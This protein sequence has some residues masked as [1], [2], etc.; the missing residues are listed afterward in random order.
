MAAAEPEG[1]L[2][3]YLAEAIGSKL[4]A[5]EARRLDDCGVIAIDRLWALRQ[6]GREH[7]LRD[8]SSDGPVGRRLGPWLTEQVP[9]QPARR[10][11]VRLLVGTY[12]RPTAGLLYHFAAVRPAWVPVAVRAS[13]AADAIDLDDANWSTGDRKWTRA[14]AR[15]AF[16]ETQDPLGISGV[17]GHGSG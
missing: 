13:W 7:P 12:R 9:D 14:S 8:L 17:E 6:A 5:D 10:S 4:L 2:S 11:I 16:L 3:D 15:Q 1:F